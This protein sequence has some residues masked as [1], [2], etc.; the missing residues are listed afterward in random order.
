MDSI[1]VVLIDDHTV[2]RDGLKMLLT[3]EPDLQVVGEAGTGEEGVVAAV[4]A[5]PHV[6]VTDVGLP[7]MDGAAVTRRLREDLPESRVLV[8]TVHDEDHY[9]VTLM[10][11]GASGYL[12]KN[13]AGAELV[14]AIRAVA[15]GR[16]WLS[17]EV[18][19]RLVARD[20]SPAENAIEPLTS[21]EREVLVLVAGAASN[22]EIA[23]SLGI[24]PRTVETHLANIY[25]KLQVRGRTEA[26]L[27]AI[28]EGITG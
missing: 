4:A 24:S 17:P 1:R 25:G 19:R 5:R 27:W 12:L 23:D 3:L 14:D 21:R 16:P 13:A 7:D 8:L 22:R 11:A 2:L 26:M 9:I 6:V 18:A 15:G 20:L 10:R 28:R